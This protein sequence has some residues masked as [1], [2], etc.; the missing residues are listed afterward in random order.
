MSHQD[1]V[2]KKRTLHVHPTCAEYGFEPAKNQAGEN[3]GSQ[4]TTSAKDTKDVGQ[5]KKKVSNS[6]L[7]AQDRQRLASTPEGRERGIIMA[8]IFLR[9]LGGSGKIQ[10]ASR[11]KSSITLELKDHAASAA[12]QEELVFGSIRSCT[13]TKSAVRNR[14]IVTLHLDSNKNAY[15]MFDALC[16]KAFLWTNMELFWALLGGA[17]VIFVLMH[18]AHW[19]FANAF[20][21]GAGVFI[22]TGL[23]LMRFHRVAPVYAG[24]LAVLTA[25]LTYRSGASGTE[26]IVTAIGIFISWWIMIG[27]IELIVSHF[28]RNQKGA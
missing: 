16:R 13:V 10:D 21:P 15:D 3:V 14:Q 9:G 19:V 17:F 4:N 1:I 11:K 27:L 12:G 22:I 24:L 6:F 25:W 7:T 23:F 5:T 8:E 28:V 2:S 20:W 26:S 18:T